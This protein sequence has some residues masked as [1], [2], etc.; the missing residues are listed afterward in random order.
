VSRN[1]RVSRRSGRRR[2]SSAAGS[3]DVPAGRTG[4]RAGAELCA[5]V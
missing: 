5:R 1:K 2:R 4:P 3:W